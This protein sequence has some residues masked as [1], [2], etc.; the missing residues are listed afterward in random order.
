MEAIKLLEKYPLSTEVVRESFIQKMI[1]SVKGDT[2]VPEDF[3]NFMIEQG[4]PNDRLCIFIDSNPRSL[5]DVFDENDII[6]IIKHHENFGFTWAVEE[7]DEQS[8]YKTRK[9]AETFAIETAFGILE[10]KLGEERMTII[11]QNGNTGEH[12]EETS[13]NN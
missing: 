8:F 4:I 11:A 10:E 2:T 13:K 12:Y 9:E 7:K 6:V 1:E 5:F 3:K